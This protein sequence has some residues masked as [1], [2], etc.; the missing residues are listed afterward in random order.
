MYRVGDSVEIISPKSQLRGLFGVIVSGPN[1]NDIY[2]VK[3]D[4]SQLLPMGWFGGYLVSVAESDLVYYLVYNKGT[5][6]FDSEF[7]NNLDSLFDDLVKCDCGGEKAKTTHTFWCKKY[8][9]Y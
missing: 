9:P 2:E 4:P 8:K 6:T 3:L 5:A 7:I 1:I